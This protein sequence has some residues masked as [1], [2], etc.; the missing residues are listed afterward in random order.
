MREKRMKKEMRT[1]EKN[2][3]EELGKGRVLPVK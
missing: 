1:Q 3:E 2:D